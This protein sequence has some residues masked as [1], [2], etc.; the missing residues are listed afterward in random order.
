[1]SYCFKCGTKAGDGAMFC[2]KCGTRLQNIEADQG[3]RSQ[4]ERTY[5]QANEF[6]EINSGEPEVK[7]M[8]KAAN[9]FRGIEGVGGKLILTNKRIIF[10]PHALNFQTQ[11]EE[12]L[13][14]DISSVGERSTGGL[15]P[16][17]MFVVTKSGYE[18]KF[19]VWGRKELIN[20]INSRL[21]QF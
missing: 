19:V 4:V 3:V 8:E 20:Y 11:Q 5:P 10:K 14:K 21:S 2:M 6:N 16:N 12:I 9:L 18:Y 17:G 1:M 15:I 13:Y 7:V